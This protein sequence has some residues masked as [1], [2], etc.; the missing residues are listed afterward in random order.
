[1]L[2]GHGFGRVFNYKTIE[3][4]PSTLLIQNLIKNSLPS[5]YFDRKGQ[6]VLQ[7]RK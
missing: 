7:I 3:K 6:S 4:K 5:E 1:M 2:M